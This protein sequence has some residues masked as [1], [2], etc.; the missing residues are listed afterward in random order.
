[1]KQK[2]SLSGGDKDF[3]VYRQNFMANF[4][5]G[6]KYVSYWVDTLGATPFLFCGGGHG[7][8]RYLY[9]NIYSGRVHLLL[10]GR[11][12]AVKLSQVIP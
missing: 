2:I 9:Q 12:G 7:V 5:G 1:M 3:K 11:K 10:W 4:M 8:H 6:Q